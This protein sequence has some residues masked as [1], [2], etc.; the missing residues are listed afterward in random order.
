MGLKFNTF[1]FVKLIYRF[2]IKCAK[3][4]KLNGN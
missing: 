3:E 1:R 2:I 4:I